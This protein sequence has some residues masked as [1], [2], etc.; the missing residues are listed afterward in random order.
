MVQRRGWIGLA[1]LVAVLALPCAAAADSLVYV[2]AGNV[3]IANADGSNAYQVTLDGTA[4]NP[5]EPPSQADDATIA[6]VRATAPPRRQLSRMRKNG[7]LL[8]PPIDTPAPG[9]GALDAKVS[10]D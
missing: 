5:Y 9:T 10:P 8:T 7:E 6:A 4:A 2:K 1:A 3:W